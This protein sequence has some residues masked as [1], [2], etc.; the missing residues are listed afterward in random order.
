M[1]RTQK[2]S[3]FIISTLVVF[4][5]ACTSSHDPTAIEVRRLSGPPVD[6]TA[7][8]CTMAD[9]Q[10]PCDPVEGQPSSISVWSPAEDVV[11]IGLSRNS[12][13]QAWDGPA[14]FA[15]LNLRFMRDG[16]LVVTAYDYRSAGGWI[17][18][19]RRQIPLDGWIQPTVTSPTPDGRNAG[20]FSLTF[21]WGTIEGT[22]DSADAPPPR[23]PE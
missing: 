3:T 2:V 8:V 17:G 7:F 14:A 13:A 11:G 15:V 22:Y 20:R 12:S 21:D 16:G 6:G 19:E 5:S 1:D 10:T 9:V 4:A 23:Q 18:N